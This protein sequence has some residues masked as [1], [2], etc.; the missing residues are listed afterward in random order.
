[1]TRMYL[2]FATLTQVILEKKLPCKY[3]MKARKMHFDI[4][5]VLLLV[6][7]TEVLFAEIK[8]TA[9]MYHLSLQACA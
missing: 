3:K 4:E 9:K 5:Q 7:L 6:T 1:M 2:L 8:S